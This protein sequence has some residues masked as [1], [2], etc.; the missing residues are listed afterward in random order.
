[1]YLKYVKEVLHYTLTRS[2]VGGKTSSGYGVFDPTEGRPWA[3]S[4]EAE[5][6]RQVGPSTGSPSGRGRTPSGIDPRSPHYRARRWK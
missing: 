6:R 4:G 1:D 5:A 3:P 2:G